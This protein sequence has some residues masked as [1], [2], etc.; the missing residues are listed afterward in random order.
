MLDGVVIDDAKVFT[1]NSA[2]RRTAASAAR[3]VEQQT[4]TET[5]AIFI[6]C[7]TMYSLHRASSC[8]AR[9]RR[10]TLAVTNLQH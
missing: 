5:K 3:P 2:N 4:P 7:T 6:G 9:L 10:S 1:T 8:M